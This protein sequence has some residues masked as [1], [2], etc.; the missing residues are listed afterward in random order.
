MPPNKLQLAKPHPCQYLPGQIEQVVVA[1]LSAIHPVASYQPFLESGFRRNQ[2][3]AYRPACPSCNACLSVRLVVEEFR[4]Q[5][6]HRRIWQRN[7][8]LAGYEKTAQATPE[9][10]ALF[11]RYQR[12]R[13]PESP[14][15]AM[16]FSAFQQWIDRTPVD[17]ALFEW[18]DADNLLRAACLVDKV[19][20]GLSAVYSYYDPDREKRSLG[21]YVIL[22]LADETL[23]RSLPF[24]YLGYWIDGSRTMA[25]K[26]RYQPLE[27][28]RG[29]H[30]HRMEKL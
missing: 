4:R 25:Y 7:Q 26:I 28:Y 10:Y 21:S 9:H 19:T 6:N 5:H 23:R 27:F 30:W 20:N 15:A 14:M 8:D 13:H 16:D 11:A 18:R 17:S 2:T 3:V 1:D 22:S 24:L 29:A 12:K